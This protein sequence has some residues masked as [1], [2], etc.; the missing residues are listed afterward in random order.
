MEKLMRLLIAPQ[1]FKGSLSARQAAAAIAEGIRRALPEAEVDLLP[2][3][4]GGPGTVEALVAACG[5]RC[6]Q[7]SVTDPLGRPIEAVWGLLEDAASAVIE[8]AAASGLVLLRAEER[9]PR[10]ASTYGTGQLIRAALDS[11]CRRIIVGV[12][13]S[14]T[15]DGGAG[16]AQAL[17]ARLLD[18]RGDELPA[19]GG[20]AL[21]RLG[22]IDVSGLD[23]RLAGCRVLVAVD[24][25]N[26]LCGPTGASMVYGPQKGATPEMAR[27]LDAALT[28]YAHVIERDLGVAVAELPGAGAAGGLAAGLV[29]FLGAE[30]GPGVDLIAEAAGLADRLARADL[31]LTGE[32]RLDAQTSYG[33]TV[34][35]VA[36][37]AKERG[38]PVIALAGE[39]AADAASLREQG[40]DAA[41]SIAPGPMT[42]A[43]SEARAAELLSAAAERVGRLLALAPEVRP[44]RGVVDPD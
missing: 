26:P 6:L 32:G 16:M 12:G 9:D 23:P 2:M 11:G 24:V 7:S 30:V 22:R 21:A 15:N 3:A 29:A 42:L 28:H 36:R 10:V 33:K 1:E 18:E 44:D 43:E 34:A 17:G 31:V 5:G 25:T 35:G 40:I 27:E 20:R 14:A 8:M 37:M 41:L 38:L 13:G 4:D 39:V 19:S